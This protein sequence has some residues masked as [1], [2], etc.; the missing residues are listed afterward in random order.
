MSHL[1]QLRT[2]LEAY[3]SGSL[4]RAAERLGI[5]QP[6][7]SAHVQS[8]EALLE[9]PLFTRRARGVEPT[10]VA[11]ELA[12]SLGGAFDA[13]EAGLAQVKARSTQLSG[14]VHVAG[15][16]EF[17][18][19]RVTPA[20]AG[21][22][23]LGLRVRLLTG[24]RERIYG[25]LAD[26]TAD[27]AV[28]ASHPG[29]RGYGFAELARERLLLVAAPPIARR[30]DGPPT[31]AALRALPAVA[32]D[33]DLPLA[34]EFFRHAFGEEPDLQAAV[35]VAD[36]RVVRRLACLGAGW[37]VVP[38]YLCADDLAAGRLVTLVPPEGSPGN[39]LYLAWDK[40]A[41]RH[42]RVAFLKDHLLAYGG[43]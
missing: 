43:I 23:A 24:N 18:G 5:T 31:A 27:L 13:V 7:A 39:S 36:L 16:A 8:L 37:T 17:M 1:V 6:A 22:P 40:G 4:S 19:E 42:P 38:D 41:L 28:T 34:R 25:L 15:P 11:H 26:G 2:F 30:L 12:R 33:E 10:A 21:L 29:E 20:L 3:R 14:T 32:Y 35:C 9:K